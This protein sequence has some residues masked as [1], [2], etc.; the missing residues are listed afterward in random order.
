MNR[1]TAARIE[2]RWNRREVEGGRVGLAKLGDAEFSGAVQ[3]GGGWLYMLNGRVVGTVGGTLAGL[4]DESHFDAYETPHPS[5]PLLFAMHEQ[6]VEPEARYFTDDTPLEEVHET[7]SSG[8]FTGYVELS[9]NVHSGD[10]YIVYYGGRA[11]HAAFVGSTEK[12]LTDQEAFERANDE[13]GIFEVNAVDLDVQEVPEPPDDVTGAA[14][15]DESGS[16]DAQGQSS[17]DTEPAATEEPAASMDASGTE[18]QVEETTNETSSQ[19]APKEDIKGS[20]LSDSET[21]EPTTDSEAAAPGTEEI[22]K[23]TTDE[24]TSVSS[25]RADRTDTST[26][27]RETADGRTGSE[28]P[29]GDTGTYDS[30]PAPSTSRREGSQ[31]E[32]EVAW[33]ER[34]TVPALD[35]ERT[36]SSPDE[37]ASQ[38][39]ARTGEFATSQEDRS[40]SS[41]AATPSPQAER[42]QSLEA[43][44]KEL[45]NQLSTIEQERTELHDDRE[46]LIQE[47]DRL[48]SRVEQLE[49]GDE[50]GRS[51]P[52][53]RS[54]EDV[55]PKTD[56]FVRYDSKSDTTLE[57]V[58]E[59][60][61]SRE[62]LGANLR[63]ESHTRFDASEVTVEGQDFDSFLQNTLAYRFAAWAVKSFAFEIRETDNQAVLRDLYEALPEI[64]RVEFD[65]TVTT[66]TDDGEES[67]L[68]FDLV[69][70]NQMGQPLVV[71][72][73]DEGRDPTGGERVDDLLE[74]ATSL[75]EAQGT[76]TTSILVTASFFHNEVHE[77]VKRATKTGFLDRDSRRSFVKT[78]RNDG[79]H[80]CLVE[81]RDEAFH[82]SRPDL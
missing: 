28:A 9:E 57:D 74:R 33:R 40:T 39:K 6:N 27:D 54:P 21:A 4:L 60:N 69:F 68:R 73:I 5:L 1:D 63:L 81:A 79:F 23:D 17:T 41:K 44:I 48:K 25:D 55:L 24:P 58:L 10:Y 61:A 65:G 26:E 29:G 70:R 67:R 82:L 31:V 50:T 11:L 45:R 71:A 53:D 2:E 16:E 7:L 64:D 76:L 36:G 47:R 22:P 35:P 8:S 66:R 12:L 13:V 52:N 59:G 18:E 43:E 49:D 56:L 77:S 37:A 34:R 80:I 20:P 75:V 14:V 72:D 78:G 46:E 42:I 15:A 30:D 62:S 3:L 38:K 19:S 32:E 51:G